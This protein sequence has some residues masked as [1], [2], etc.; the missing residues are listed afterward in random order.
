MGY[1]TLILLYIKWM[2]SLICYTKIKN[3]LV[4]KYKWNAFF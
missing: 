4:I 2:N 1:I 3:D